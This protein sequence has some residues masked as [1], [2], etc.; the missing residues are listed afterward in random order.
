M[1]ELLENTKNTSLVEAPVAG[2]VS[3]L[4][5][6]FSVARQSASTIVPYLSYSAQ[7]IGKTGIVGLTLV[8]FS[9]I[10]F[11]SGNLP[12]H[13]QYAD[14]STE[15]AQVR[16]E[17]DD[18]RAG[19]IAESPQ[20]K[21]GRFVEGLPTIDDVPIVM[22]SIVTVAAASGIELEQGTYEYVAPD[23]A[24]IARYQMTLPVVGTYPE[25]R[26]FI[27]NVLATAPAVS[28][29]SLRIERG[30]VADTTITADLKFSILL[31][32]TL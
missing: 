20:I 9:A 15:L 30:R 2:E 10:T 23:G 28:L 1:S 31:G 3:R 14:Q 8:V 26:K 5:S 12:L 24:T 27:E 18:L 29:D 25:I 32:G 16:T 22:G 17:A 13:Q 21:A 11:I 4:T 7:R 19:T 6:S